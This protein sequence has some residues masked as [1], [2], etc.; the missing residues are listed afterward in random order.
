MTGGWIAVAVI[1]WSVGMWLIG[2]VV[3]WCTRGW[4]WD[5]AGDW[6]RRQ[7]WERAMDAIDRKQRRTR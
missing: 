7:E 5:A 1:G 4:D 2:F 3:G 6:D